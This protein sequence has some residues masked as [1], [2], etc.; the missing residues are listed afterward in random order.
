M[1]VSAVSVPDA[2][3]DPKHPDHDRWVKETTLA[4]EVR[5]AQLMGGTLR[6]AE[7]ENARLL[8]RMEALAREA[9]PAIAKP[10]KSRQ[11]RA[12]DR[13]VTVKAALPRKELTL[14]Q[15]SPCGRCGVCRACMRER[16]IVAIT[17]KAKSERDGWAIQTMWKMAMLLWQAQAKAGPFLG[18]TKRDANRIITAAAEKVCDESV[19]HGFGRWL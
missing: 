17:A 16:R 2:A 7:A 15:L 8:V 9:K 18:K 6:D 12:L 11:E 13:A 14:Q 5:H 1:K 10:R 4:M 19:H 3:S